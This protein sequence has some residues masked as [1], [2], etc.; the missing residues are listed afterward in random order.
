MWQ[1]GRERK[2]SECLGDGVGL[3]T[4][5]HVWFMWQRNAGAMLPAMRLNVERCT[6]LTPR[7]YETS[8]TNPLCSRKTVPSLRYVM[9][10]INVYHFLVLLLGAFHC[11]NK[12]EIW[13]SKSQPQTFLVTRHIHQPPAIKLTRECWKIF[14]FLISS[15]SFYAYEFIVWQKCK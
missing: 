15:N 2:G 3:L 10:H 5:S 1:Q 8:V 11:L 12:I 7:G 9:S 6:L 14:E 13:Y 4:S